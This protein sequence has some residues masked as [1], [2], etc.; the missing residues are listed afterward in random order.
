MANGRGGIQFIPTRNPFAELG[1]GAQNLVSGLSQQFQQRQQA[2]QLGLLGQQIQGGGQIDPRA[3]TN[4]LVGQLALQAILQQQQPQPGFTLGPGQQ[5]FGPGGQQI[6][7]APVVPIPKAGA[8]QIARTGDESGFPEGTVFQAGPAGKI[9]VLSE[10]GGGGLSG[11]EKTKLAVTQA[12]EFRDDPRI[13]DV[14]IV[15]RS[16]R[17]MAA[18]LKLATAA[19]AKS[20]IASDQALG[21]LFQK[22]LDPT[23]VVRESEFARTPEGAAAVNR[24]LAIAPQLRFGGLRLLDTDRRALVT[25]A[26][27]LLRESKI[28][29][30]RAFGE[31]SIRADE[32]GL[33]KKIVF[34]GKEPFVIE[35]EDGGVQL[36]P[37]TSDT[38]TEIDREIAELQAQLQQPVVQPSP[39]ITPAPAQQRSALLDGVDAVTGAE[40]RAPAAKAP[41]RVQMLNSKGA[42]F[43]VPVK[44]IRKRL[45]QDFTL[46]SD[47]NVRIGKNTTKQNK[48]IKGLTV[49]PGQEIISFDGGRT[50]QLIP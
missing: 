25:M 46:P 8:L 36:G 7:Q 9:T 15:E 6:A 45:A 24:L 40:K 2:Q 18:A 49:R 43:Q 39:V 10:P 26:R 5:R 41:T 38:L 23:S 22:M 3:F 35:P 19:D 48:N 31:F 50:W 1:L 33:N 27:K 44:D 4:P 42:L 14:Q 34:G 28:T 32:I 37:G 47:S 13:K 20:R 21:V 16:E 29:A 12:K 17:G 11:V 30:N